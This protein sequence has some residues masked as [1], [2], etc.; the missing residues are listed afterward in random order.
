M[1]M[2]PRAHVEANVVEREIRIA[3]APEVVFNYFID[4]EKMIQWKGIE[5]TLDPR[6]GGMYRVNV[7]GREVARGEYREIVPYTRIVISWGWEG[8]G[9]P[10]PPGSSTVEVSLTPDG[11]GTLL[12]LVHRDLPS[13]ATGPHAEGWD[14][15]LARLAIA[16]GG[17]NAG[18][19]PWTQGPPPAE[20]PT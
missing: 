16:A 3:A 12:R 8:E 6:P 5:A 7:T 15:F 19:D 1:T 17:G 4:P 2:T 20:Q 14:H 11:D 13:L 10:V 9:N 18:I